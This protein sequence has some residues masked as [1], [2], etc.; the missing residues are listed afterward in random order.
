M[1]CGYKPDVG[2]CDGPVFTK[3][4]ARRRTRDRVRQAKCYVASLHQDNE[5]W[6]DDD[7]L[8]MLS[9]VHKAK[10]LYAF[11]SLNSSR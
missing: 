6:P 5:D 7:S 9:E 10:G 11:D 2:K 1:P 4:R 8:S 3:P